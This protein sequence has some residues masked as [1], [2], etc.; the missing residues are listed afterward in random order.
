MENAYTDLPIK[1]K[2]DIS[3]GSNWGEL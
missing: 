1:L 2:T 3:T